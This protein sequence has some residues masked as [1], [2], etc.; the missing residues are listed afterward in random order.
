MER[1]S[2]GDGRGLG[3]PP[4]N[5]SMER[6]QAMLRSA[7]EKVQEG[8]P[9]EALEALILVIQGLYGNHAV[10]P[11][12]HHARQRF[13]ADLTASHGAGAGGDVNMDQIT[14][15]LSRVCLTISNDGA[16]SGSRESEA[17]ALSES[18]HPSG[19]AIPPQ[20][21]PPMPP[22]THAQAEPPQMLLAER[23]REGIVQ[24]ALADGSSFVCVHC[25]GVYALTRQATY[26]M[27]CPAPR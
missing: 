18:A 9:R 15:L 17:N 26:H 4:G 23:G 8:R 13:T 21:S 10:L 16:G 5:L 1:D 6:C 19:G 27:W 20:P 25:G 7:S 22:G 2:L 11:M 24:A 12:L 3:T 14:A